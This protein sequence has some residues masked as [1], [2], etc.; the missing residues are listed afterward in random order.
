MYNHNKAQQSKNRVHISWD[1][2]Y[3]WKTDAYQYYSG[4]MYL[5]FSMLNIVGLTLI[6]FLKIVIFCFKFYRN[7]FLGSIGQ[8]ST[9]C[10]GNIFT[11]KV[12]DPWY[13]IAQ[14][15][16][17]IMIVVG[18]NRRIKHLISSKPVLCCKRITDPKDIMWISP[19]ALAWWKSICNSLL[20][21]RHGLQ[22]GRPVNNN[23]FIHW[24]NLTRNHYPGIFPFKISSSS[25]WFEIWFKGKYV[26][27]R[28]ELESKEINNAYW[29]S[30]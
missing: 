4:L 2:L 1:I 7:L 6:L 11:E 3:D 10:Y 8:Y 29:I 21:Y 13:K 30:I 28:Y 22:F 26:T 19:A 17:A 25:L 9:I 14:M 27:G 18:N 5:A 24:F 12:S 15:K 23:G 16:G 20:K